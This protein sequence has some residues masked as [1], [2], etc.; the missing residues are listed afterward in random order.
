M[1]DYK[2]SF[3][4]LYAKKL[5][6]E[7]LRELDEKQDFCTF[8]DITWRSNWG[9]HEELPFYNTSDPFY[10]EQSFGL[11]ADEEGIPVSTQKHYNHKELF[12]SKYHRGQLLFV[13][14]ITIFHKGSVKHFIEVIH[15]SPPNELKLNKIKWFFQ[16]KGSYAYIWTIPADHILGQIEKPNSL[17]FELILEV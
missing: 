5:L 10:F 17:S 9:V 6:L 16:Y 4:H 15:K 2:E 11:L 7:W 14:D 1:F 12:D 3:K 13:P 8:G